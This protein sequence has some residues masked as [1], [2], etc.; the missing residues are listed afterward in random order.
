MTVLEMYGCG[1]GS[2]TWLDWAGCSGGK[3]RGRVCLGW[4]WVW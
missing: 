2:V 3:V 4:T 1:T